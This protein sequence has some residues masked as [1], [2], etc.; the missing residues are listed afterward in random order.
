VYTDA[1]QLLAS[2]TQK[3]A[4]VPGAAPDMLTVTSVLVNFSVARALSPGL[5][6]EEALLFTIDQTPLQV[7]HF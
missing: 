3:D 6:E 1:Y 2:V 4:P 5:L 7:F